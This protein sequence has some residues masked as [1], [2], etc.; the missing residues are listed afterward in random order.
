MQSAGDDLISVSVIDAAAAQALARRLRRT[1]EWREVVPGLSSVVVQF[2]AAIINREQAEQQV[3]A[4]LTSDDDGSAAPVQQFNVPVTYDGADLANV[5]NA[6]GLSENEFVALHTARDYDVEMLGFTPGFA[7]LG[8]PDERLAVPR[9]ATPR[10]IVAAGSVGIAGGRSGIYALQG[11]GGWPLVG[12]TDLT[13]FDPTADEP[14][15][16]TPGTIVRFV[17]VGSS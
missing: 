10:Q 6:L 16:L 9:L 2:D 4:A 11:P 13:L 1:G 8:G 5:C 14:F 17:E 7:Y 12:R 15:L 3:G